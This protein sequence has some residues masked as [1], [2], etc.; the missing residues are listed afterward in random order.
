MGDEWFP[1]GLGTHHADPQVSAAAAPL[2][3]CCLVRPHCGV[4]FAARSIISIRRLQACRAQA[5]EP[6][7]GAPPGKLPPWDVMWE[8][9]LDDKVR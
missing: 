6:K 4:T 3:I 9:L 8:S 1:T 7:A 2:V 5:A